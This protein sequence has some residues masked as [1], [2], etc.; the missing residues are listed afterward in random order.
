VGALQQMAYRHKIS[1]AGMH[2]SGLLDQL[3]QDTLICSLMLYSV[4]ADF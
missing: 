4:D 2:A 3:S 1:S